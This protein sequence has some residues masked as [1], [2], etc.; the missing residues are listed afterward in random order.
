MEAGDREM[1]EIG[2]HDVKATKNQLKK[3]LKKA[4]EASCPMELTPGLSTAVDN[5]VRI[6]TKLKILEKRQ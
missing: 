3:S 4:L 1:S 2:I 5:Y 6:V